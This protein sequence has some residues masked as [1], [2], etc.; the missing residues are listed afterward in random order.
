MRSFE[1]FSA[2]RYVAAG[3]FLLAFAASPLQAQPTYTWTGGAGTTNFLLPGNWD[4]AGPPGLLGSAPGALTNTNIALFAAQGTT[5]TTNLT[6]GNNGWALGAI[7]TAGNIGGLMTLNLN[8]NNQFRLNGSTVVTTTGTY[9]NVAAAA[10]GSRDLTINTAG[11]TFAFGTTGQA[12][13]FYAD[14]GRTLTINSQNKVNNGG[15]LNKEGAGILILAGDG[16]LNLNA[17]L[18]INKGTVGVRGDFGATAINVASGAKLQAGL[19]PGDTLGT[20]ATINF[21]SGGALKILTNGTT[22]SKL[23]NAT[24]SKSSTSEIFQ[25]VISPTQLG[26]FTLSSPTLF[27]GTL[28]NF[29]Q[30]TFTQA[31]PGSYQV[32]G[33]GFIISNWSLTV[34]ASQINLNSISVVPIPEP[35]T[36]LL[37]GSAGLAAVGGIRRRFKKRAVTTP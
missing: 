18:N 24:L 27:Q 25:L 3:A 7:V 28:L 21:Q 29:T 16:N 33:D 13:T 15:A 2:T 6:D 19:T 11:F 1:L 4:T 17:P 35:T 9:N 31:S 23:Q 32:V 5:A 34:T 37:I 20:N 8:G 26:N 12:T 36:V 22:V 10:M 30:G 14:A